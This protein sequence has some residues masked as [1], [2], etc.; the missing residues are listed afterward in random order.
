MKFQSMPR[1]KRLRRVV[2]PPGFKGF[3]PYGNW[4]E[5]EEAVE[6][7][8]EEYESIKLTDYS[9]LNHE[10]ASV[11]MEVS[12]ATFA[13]VYESARQKKHREYKRW[14]ESSKR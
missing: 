2:V 14:I 5:K 8:F 4:R 7:L 9:G 13:R 11:L 12:R 3:K 10:E 1:K 6:L